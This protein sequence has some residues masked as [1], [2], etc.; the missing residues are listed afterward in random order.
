MRDL[1]EEAKAETM[2][3]K[4]EAFSRKMI[5][6]VA[7]GEPLGARSSLIDLS[8]RS[9][10]PQKNFGQEYFSGMVMQQT[11]DPIED[12]EFDELFKH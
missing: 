7:T 9:P 1:L 11:K 4:A 6:N 3:K 8:S 12:A 5:D 10:S 2:V